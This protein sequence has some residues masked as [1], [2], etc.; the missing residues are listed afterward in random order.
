[1]SLRN[2]LLVVLVILAATTLAANG[3]SL[4]M[5]SVL[6][7]LAGAE[8]QAAAAQAQVRGVLIS[9][10]CAVVGIGAFIQLA[11]ALSAAIGGEPAGVVE[12]VKRIAGGD[13][14]F[15]IETR[16]G[17]STSLLAA[18]ATMQNE[19]RQMVS[20][21]REASG[22]LGDAT[23]G[24]AALTEQIRVGADN[25]SAAAMNTVTSVDSVTMSISRVADSAA[26]VDRNCS[27]SLERISDGNESASKM[28]GEI[29]E[30]E[31]A[32]ADIA[33]T[34][35][36]F[37]ESVNSITRMTREVRDIADQ[38]NLLAL[39]AAI[40]AARAGEQGRGFAVV[41]DEVRKLAEKSAATAGEIDQVTRLI[42]QKSDTVD[43][44]LK[45]GETALITSQEYL[46]NVAMVLGDANASV[47]QTT[48]G[49]GQITA[50]VRDQGE[51]T[52]DISRHVE[53]IARMAGENAAIAANAARSAAELQEL[54]ASMDAVS[55]RFR[56]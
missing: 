17:D 24:F 43:A 39:N 48:A 27:S 5:F 47:S 23:V 51:A 19:L 46:E 32:V 30:V 49:M 11:R 42:G 40:E 38:T 7:G 8:L 35:K 20:N 45:K 28:I 14:A 33:T 18:I 52:V 12:V 55:G 6:T 54:V 3:Y 9:G 21:L 22:R 34:T 10:V 4:Y 37:I 25:Q 2:R 13:L 41:A 56:L 31:S 36:D 16:P 1:M 15:R 44:A 50:A 26:E 29:S 53:T